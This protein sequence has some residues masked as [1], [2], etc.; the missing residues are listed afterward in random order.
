MHEVCPFEQLS[1][2]VSEHAALGAMPEHI[3]GAEQGDVELTY[4]HPSV[5]CAHI[6]TVWLSWHAVPF[7]VQAVALQEHEA[8]P[9]MLV[10]H[11]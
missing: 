10:E 3:C 8:V 6:A 9:L 5:S 11:A 7:W 4:K 1:L 2:H